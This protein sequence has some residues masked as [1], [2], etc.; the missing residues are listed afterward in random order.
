MPLRTDLKKVLVIGSGPIIIGQAAEFDYA[1]TQACKALKEDGICV[2]L[3]NSNPATIMTDKNMADKIYLE[4]LNIDVL[5]RIIEIERP[6]A[7]LSNLGGQ[8]GLNLSIELTESGFLDQFGVK[9]LGAKVET[10]RK[11]EDRQAF[12]DTMEEIGEPCIASKVV[13]TIYDAVVASPGR[14][15]VHRQG[16]E[17]PEAAALLRAGE[18]APGRA[19]PRAA[20]DGRKAH[21]EPLPR[22]GGDPGRV[23][24]QA[25]V[26]RGGGA[27]REH[28][29]RPGVL[30]GQLAPAGRVRRPRRPAR[31]REGVA[32]GEHPRPAR[33]LHDRDALQ[34]DGEEAPPGDW[35]RRPRPRRRRPR[36]ARAGR[37]GRRNRT[38]RGRMHGR[39]MRREGE[40]RL[41]CV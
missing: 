39:R 13:T 16:A 12:K 9:L 14:D 21:D 35:P 30:R 28:G 34:G 6:D 40:T 22:A 5:K 10:I 2:V 29:A 15:A 27:L 8:M 7:I 1:G 23:G 19:R 11:A 20:A 17:P 25:R 24:S 26:A 3:V 41:R 38:H 31:G 33:A 36:G 18:G 37:R 32:P 4:P